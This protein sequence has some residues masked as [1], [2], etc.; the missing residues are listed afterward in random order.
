VCRAWREGC[1]GEQEDGLGVRRAVGVREAEG[2]GRGEGC[3][4]EGEGTV[5]EK[6]KGGGRR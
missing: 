3:V 2:G 4:E 5:R 1:A 6:G